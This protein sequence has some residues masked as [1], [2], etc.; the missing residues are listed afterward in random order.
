MVEYEKALEDY[1][2]KPNLK[3]LSALQS[4]LS[5]LGANGASDLLLS[6][7]SAYAESCGKLSSKTE[8][9]EEYRRIHD[10]MG[11][12]HDVNLNATNINIAQVGSNAVTNSTVAGSVGASLVLANCWNSINKV[13]DEAKK[14]LLSELHTIVQDT[15]AKLS[16]ETD[17]ARLEQKYAAV[18]SEATSTNPDVKWYRVS[19]EGIVEAAGAV[20]NLG[21]RASKII[22]DLAKIVPGLSGQ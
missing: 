4:A 15:L 12:Q 5:T 2:Q 16:A 20:L 19:G 21:E 7:A 13:E 8:I 17:R 1:L 9:I 18:V 11:N 3:N 22:T 10:K 14:G 6:L